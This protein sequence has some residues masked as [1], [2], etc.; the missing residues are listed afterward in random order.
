MTSPHVQPRAILVVIAGVIGLTSW[1]ASASVVRDRIYRP[2][3]MPDKPEWVGMPAPETITVRT[4]DGLDL[5]G[6]RWPATQSPH[7]T[8]V[9]F[10]GNG[11]NRY[12]AAQLAAPLRRKAAE[13]IIASY[14]GYGGN[15]GAPDE[16]GLYRD[17]AAFLQAARRSHPQKLYLFGF[18]LGGGVAL[19]LAADDRVDGVVTLGTFSSLRSVAP[20]WTR[21]LLPDRFDNLAAVRRTSSPLLLLHGTADEMVPIREAELI[22]AAAGANVR[23]LRLSG[24]PHNVALDQL[25]DRIWQE[26]GQ[27]PGVATTPDSMPR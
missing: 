10:H 9:F 3:P 4:A 17:G 22:Q 7:V 27:M 25:A 26:I 14:R 13:I 11:G 20:R 8:L 5:Q 12:T 1:L 19:R 16:Q 6:Y 2:D 23:F 21:G 24:A 15:P 18:S